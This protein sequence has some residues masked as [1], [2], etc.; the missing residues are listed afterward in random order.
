MNKVTLL[1]RI[2]PEGER[3]SEVVVEYDSEIDGSNL[4]PDSYAVEAKAGDTT[5]ERGRHNG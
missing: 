5:V 2:F 3:V 4:T 1:T